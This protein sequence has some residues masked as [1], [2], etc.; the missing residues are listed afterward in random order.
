VQRPDVVYAF[1]MDVGRT[2]HR[3]M[4]ERRNLLFGVVTYAAGR[5]GDEPVR[6]QGHVHAVSPRSGWLFPEMFEIWS[7]RAVVYMQ[8]RAAKDPGC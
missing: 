5:L 3:R 2:E 8:E 6:S 1:A 4:L 7:G